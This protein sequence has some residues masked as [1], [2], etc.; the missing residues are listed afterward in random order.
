MPVHAA[1]RLC[2]AMSTTENIIFPGHETKHENSAISPHLSTDAAIVATQQ[3]MLSHELPLSMQSRTVS[4]FCAKPELSSERSSSPS[5][6]EM[7]Y[8]S[9]YG[10]TRVKSMPQH[11][12]RSTFVNDSL[13]VG[14]MQPSSTLQLDGVSYISRACLKRWTSGT[15]DG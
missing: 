7:F 11:D 1:R 6:E 2:L 4:A 5:P 12:E 8:P 14:T 3:N 9:E 15:R 10:P 13:K